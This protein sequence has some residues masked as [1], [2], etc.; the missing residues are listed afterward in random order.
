VRSTGHRAGIGE[1][2]RFAVDEHTVDLEMKL[3]WLEKYVGDLDVVVR[4][5]SDEVVALRREVTEL[6]EAA[7]R[8]ASGAPGGDGEEDDEEPVLRYEVPP[9]Y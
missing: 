2:G 5:L 7:A 1:R 6:R 8:P 3:A 4:G 9:H